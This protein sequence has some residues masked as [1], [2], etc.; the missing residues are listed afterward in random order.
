M[1]QDPWC[2]QRQMQLHWVGKSCFTIH[3]ICPPWANSTEHLTGGFSVSLLFQRPCGHWRVFFSPG[4]G[5]SWGAWGHVNTEQQGSGGLLPES[6]RQTAEGERSWAPEKETEICLVSP[7]HKLR[8]VASLQKWCQ[9][10]PKSLMVIHTKPVCKDWEK[11][12]LFQMPKTQSWGKNSQG[13]WRS[14]ETWPKETFK[15]QPQIKRSMNYL[16]VNAKWSYLKSS[17]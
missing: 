7:L 6:F 16:K 11:F 12:L 14:R 4:L 13:I 9:R 17:A 2:E 8:E 1:L 10:P 3:V 5:C 15:N